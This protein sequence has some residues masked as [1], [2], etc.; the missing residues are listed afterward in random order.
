MSE[1]VCSVMFLRMFRYIFLIQF[2]FNRFLQCW[3]AGFVEQ[4][5]HINCHILDPTAYVTDNGVSSCITCYNVASCDSWHSAT[6][7]IHTI[8]QSVMV[9]MPHNCGPVRAVGCYVSPVWDEICS[10]WHCLSTKEYTP[11]LITCCSEICCSL[12]HLSLTIRCGFGGR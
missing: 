3:H 10:D 11:T 12:T 1:A 4:W 9:H 5:G 8:R 2:W 7:S 6:W